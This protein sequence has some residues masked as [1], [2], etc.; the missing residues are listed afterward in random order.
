[1]NTSNSPSSTSYLDLGEYDNTQTSLFGDK[2][3]TVPL[4]IAQNASGKASHGGTAGT[5][6]LHAGT[7]IGDGI[8][9]IGRQS[10]ISSLEDWLLKQ[11][12]SNE[13]VF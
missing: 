1:M 4:D 6:M 12:S 3:F 2:T 13:Y 11:T 8:N 7:L 10:P 5:G 9:G